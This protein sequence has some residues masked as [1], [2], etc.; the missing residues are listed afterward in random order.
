LYESRENNK[1]KDWTCSE[2]PNR[3]W[4]GFL[5][6]RLRLG[7][8]TGSHGVS[9]GMSELFLAA[10][11]EAELAMKAKSAFMSQKGNETME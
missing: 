7:Q 4:F 1:K 6:L 9:F 3:N 8:E 2:V 11:C 5:E 10:L